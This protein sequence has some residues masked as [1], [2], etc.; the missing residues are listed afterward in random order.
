MTDSND[1]VRNSYINICKLV[2]ELRNSGIEGVAVEEENGQFV[3]KKDG[4][5]VDINALAVDNALRQ[6]IEALNAAQAEYERT[7][8]Q[9][10]QAVKDEIMNAVQQEYN[11]ARQQA[12]A[13]EKYTNICKLVVELRNSGIEGVTVEEENGQF[14]VKK[15]GAVVDINALAVDNA[16]RQKIEALNAAQTEYKSTGIQLAGDN[17]TEIM[18]AVALYTKVSEAEIALTTISGITIETNDGQFI[19]KKDGAVVDINTLA[20]DD[21]LRQKIEALNIAQQAYLTNGYMLNDADKTEIKNTVQT[22]I[23]AKNQ[24]EAN[25]LYADIQYVAAYISLKEGY[26]ATVSPDGSITVTGVHGETLS[27]ENLVSGNII[28]QTIAD[29]INSQ[30]ELL[31][32]LNKMPENTESIVAEQAHRVQADKEMYAKVLHHRLYIQKLTGFEIQEKEGGFVA[33]KDGQEIPLSRFAH[34]KIEPML[35]QELANGYESYMHIAEMMSDQDKAIELENQTQKMKESYLTQYYKWYEETIYNKTYL[36]LL[37]GYEISLSDGTAK[38]VNPHNLEQPIVI[39]LEQ[40]KAELPESQREKVDLALKY[41]KLFKDTA[42][43]DV[44]VTEEVLSEKQAAQKERSKTQLKQDIV[45]LYKIAQYNKSYI[46]KVT[47]YTISLIDQNATRANPDNPNE[48]ITIALDELRNQL[49]ESLKIKLDKAKEAYNQISVEGLLNRVGISNEELAGISAE[50]E[51]RVNQDVERDRNYGSQAEETL[52]NVADLQN[53]IEFMTGLKV[54]PNLVNGEISGWTIQNGEEISTVDDLSGMTQIPEDMRNSLVEAYQNVAYGYIGNGQ[55]LTSEIVS[56]KVQERRETVAKIVA[57]EAYTKMW[58]CISTKATGWMLSADG[59][60]LTKEGE[61]PKAIDAFFAEYPELA[62]QRAEYEAQQAILQRTGIELD[63][64]TR[65][66]IQNGPAP[67]PPTP[68]SSKLNQAAF[69]QNYMNILTN[70]TVSPIMDEHG[71]ISGWSIKD[72]EGTGRILSD[73]NAVL[74]DEVLR[75]KVPTASLN[76]L[77]TLYS[78]VA[79]ERKTVGMP[80][81]QEQINEAVRTQLSIAEQSVQNAKVARSKIEYVRAYI[82]E[83]H[84]IDLIT[85]R[86]ETTGEI[87]WGYLTTTEGEQQMFVSLEEMASQNLITA[88]QMVALTENT[89]YLQELGVELDSVTVQN[90][91]QE[92]ARLAHDAVLREQTENNPALADAFKKAT[93]VHNGLQIL[94][95]WSIMPVV[96]NGQ[97]TGWAIKDAEGREKTE[98]DLNGIMPEANVQKLKTLYADVVHIAQEAG[99]PVTAD[100]IQQELPATQQDAQRSVETLKTSYQLMSYTQALVKKKA[101]IDLTFTADGI[102]AKKADGTDVSLDELVAGDILTAEELASL[103][104][105]HVTYYAQG[106][107]LDNKTAEKIKAEQIHRVNDADKENQDDEHSDDEHKGDD[108][109]GDDEGNNEEDHKVETPEQRAARRRLELM[110]KPHRTSQEEKELERLNNERRRALEKRL[111]EEG[112][113]PLQEMQELTWLQQRDA[114]QQLPK[115]PATPKGIPTYSGG[116]HGGGSGGGTTVSGKPTDSTTLSEDDKNKLASAVVEGEQKGFLA[117]NW[118]WIVGAVAAVAVAIGAF[119]LI[120]KQKKKTDKAKDEVKTLTGQVSDLQTKVDELSKG[121]SENS[122]SSALAN[123]GTAVNVDSLSDDKSARQLIYD[124]QTKSM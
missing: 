15:D 92:Q 30:R 45:D 22:R 17:K 98:A 101:Q 114:V 63:E 2:V 37:T 99:T 108:A 84:Q 10:E 49:P 5:V 12:T 79:N 113:L 42:M 59:R 87:K 53:R 58:N 41:Y 74:Q 27:V 73:A 21:A 60:T 11:T 116:S 121:N 51:E 36:E 44:G 23:D 110:K 33:L 55:L 86:D 120:R 83:K 71:D 78:E 61:E 91:I 85:Q 47:G 35:I 1:V 4:A 34:E 39:N 64:A 107:E 70:Y 96:E 109:K 89:T 14:V 38:K 72:A 26:N 13:K 81:T 77:V 40:L 20:A 56:A 6:K 28:S 24:R 52:K 32:A 43:A 117:R 90:I 62:E 50:D 67:V 25:A 18:H 19:V 112:E 118:E 46:E 65:Q 68:E 100:M 104:R 75:E 93:I 123:S 124:S 66:R 57:E 69:I 31:R 29:K 97:I 8:V 119:F 122:A 95:G 54:S 76:A 94:T 88:E 9:L 115:S 80:L 102:T 111:A 48:T 105:N 82:K 3:V 16:L 106:F 103:Q 7:G